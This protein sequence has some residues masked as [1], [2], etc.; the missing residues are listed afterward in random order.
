MNRQHE[1]VGQ[2]QSIPER[3]LNTRQVIVTAKELGIA[4]AA[5]SWVVLSLSGEYSTT[6][7]QAAWKGFPDRKA[8][9]T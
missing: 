1:K 3:R 7:L 5:Y 4:V 9:E 2:T 8:Q 6:F